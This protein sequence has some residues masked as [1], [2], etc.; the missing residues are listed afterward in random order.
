MLKLRVCRGTSTCLLSIQQPFSPATTCILL[1]SQ[2]V[3]IRLGW[4][5]ARCNRIDVSIHTSIIKQAGLRIIY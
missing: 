2:E 3:G 4:F 1:R 5:W